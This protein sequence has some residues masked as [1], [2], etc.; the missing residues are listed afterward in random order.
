MDTFWIIDIFDKI[1]CIFVLVYKQLNKVYEACPLS[2]VQSTVK[3]ITTPAATNC[4]VPWV[5]RAP[6]KACRHCPVAS[7]SWAS[8][9]TAT[10]Q[11]AS[12]QLSPF[13]VSEIFILLKFPKTLHFSASKHFNTQ[14]F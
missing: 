9:A 3:A 14:Y 7:T 13:I 8:E 6:C 4:R 10:P 1:I 11:P 12:T 5:Y 2:H